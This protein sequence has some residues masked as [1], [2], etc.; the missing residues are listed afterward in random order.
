MPRLKG[1]DLNLT[2][3]DKIFLYGN[4]VLSQR[5]RDNFEVAGFIVDG[6]LSSEIDGLPVV[7]INA[8][9]SSDFVIC[10]AGGMPKTQLRK[11]QEFSCDYTHIFDLMKQYPEFL[12]DLPFNEGFSDHFRSYKAKFV[13]L[14]DQLDDDLSKTLFDS[15]IRLRHVMDVDLCDG[16]AERQSEQYF[17]DFLPDTAG[18]VFYDVGGYD[19]FT[20]AEF[21]KRYPK[22]SSVHIFEPE[23]K[24]GRVCQHRFSASEKVSVHFFGLGSEDTTVKFSGNGSSSAASDTGD[25]LIRIRRLDDLKL[26][27]PSFVKMD[28][29]GAELAAITGAKSTIAEF[30]P[31]LAIASYHGVDQ[32]WRITETVLAIHPHYRVYLRHYTESIY[33]TV[34]FFVPVN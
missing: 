5:F 24:N 16:L 28:I 1:Q 21:I 34:L 27:A 7:S 12:G 2:T 29:E 18:D 4:N 11:M 32:L 23:Q 26:A 17:E 33:E 8:V 20:S 3:Y 9:S 6:C 25:Q 14:R 31:T 13:W 19:G 22:F 30:A 15:V 10:C